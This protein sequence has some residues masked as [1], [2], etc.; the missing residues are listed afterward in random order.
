MSR[1][2]GVVLLLLAGLALAAPSRAQGGGSSGATPGHRDFEALVKAGDRA[3]AAGRSSDAIT[4]Y[5]DALK[6]RPDPLVQGRFGLLVLEAGNAPRAA[7]LLLRAIE[8]AAGA[9]SDEADAFYEAYRVARKQVCRLE[10]ETNVVG[11]AI[12]VD[13]RKVAEG[14]ASDLWAFVR[15]GPHEVRASLEGH[16]DDVKRVELPAG[17]SERIALYLRPVEPALGVEPAPSPAQAEATV[18]AE[19]PFVGSRKRAWSRPARPARWEMHKAWSM[20]FGAAVVYGAISPL[21][22]FGVA[23]WAG[24]RWEG[25]YSLELDLRAAWSPYGI[26]GNQTRGVSVAALPSLCA[27]PSNFFICAQV[28]LGGIIHEWTL[29]T[30]GGEQIAMHGA[31]RHFRVGFGAKG[32]FVIPLGG[33]LAIRLAGDLSVLTDDTPVVVGDMQLWKGHPLLGGL[34]I[35][36]EVRF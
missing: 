9:T 14:A 27:R 35:G 34:S 5:D 19:R 6:I 32:G 13:G 11:A 33:A 26:K 3:R 1:T 8:E 25:G 28:H 10:V 4:A 36:G 7:H 31:D 12:W 29:R 21:P 23:G 24:R 17:G 22:A 18:E 16:Q 20:G 30:T 2:W 15:P